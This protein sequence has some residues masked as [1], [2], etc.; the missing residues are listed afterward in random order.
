M[1]NVLA[2][3]ENFHWLVQVEFYNWESQFRM[4]VEIGS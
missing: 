2:Q 3:S 4:A 1:V